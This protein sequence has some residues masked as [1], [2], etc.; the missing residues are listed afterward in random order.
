MKDLEKWQIISFIS[1]GTAMALGLVQSFFILRILSVSEWGIVQIAVSIGAALGIYQHLGLASASTREISAAKDNKEI[2]K[3]FVTSV[4]IRYMVTIPITIGLFLLSHYLA[5]NTYKVPQIELPLKLYA[6]VLIAQGFQSILNSVIAGTKR[7][8]RLF[9][10]QAA[11]AIVSML[12]YVPMIYFYRIN[13]Y[14]YALFLFNLIA[15]VVLGYL[16]F[17]PLGRSAFELPSR[18]EL[19]HLFKELFA[20]SM[21]IYIVKI[22]YT[23]WEKL[24]PNL[25]G[26]TVTPEMVGYFGFALLYAKKLMSISDSVTDVNLPVFSDKYVNDRGSFMETFSKNFDKLFVLIIFTG[27]SAVYWVSEIVRI[28]IGS[29][30]YDPSLSLVLPL[31]FAFIFYSF[32]NII[33]SS[34]IIPAKM[35]KEMI[36]SFVVLIG[37]TLAFYFGL[38]SI[39]GSLLAMSYGM[40]TGAFLSLLFLAVISDIKLKFRLFHHEHVLLLIISA[41]IALNWPVGNIYVKISAYL[42]FIGLFIWGVSVAKFVTNNDLNKVLKKIPGF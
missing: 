6:L 3:I 15:S 32:I 26:L 27:A 16:A 34:V 13:G 7:F 30:K 25:L 2:F 5:F 31:V 10:Y 36:I 20:I 19:K 40:A 14:F 33:K 24:G 1:R 8:K 11:I 23:N 21:A 41:A 22:I 29:S 37:G 12:L 42:V 28:A 4:F 35:V 18:K 38:K 17:K 39:L 9:L